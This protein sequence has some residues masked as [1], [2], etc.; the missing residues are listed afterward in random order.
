[1]TITM[2]AKTPQDAVRALTVELQRQLELVLQEAKR[3]QTIKEQRYYEGRV[4]QL[5]GTIE[6]MSAIHYE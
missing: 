2:T 6:F 3:A 4:S 1:M 5:R